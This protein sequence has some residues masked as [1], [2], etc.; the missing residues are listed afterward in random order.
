MIVRLLEHQ[1]AWE[2]HVLLRLYG[3]PYTC[4]F[5]SYPS[6]MGRPLPLLADEENIYCGRECYDFIAKK[7]K[8]YEIIDSAD[9]LVLSYLK[10]HLCD[11]FSDYLNVT[12]ED[13]TLIDKCEISGV[14][15]FQ[16]LMYDFKRVLNQNRY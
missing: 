4:D 1:P 15:S 8:N 2:L 12:R 5:V 10:C 11:M 3:I 7:S 6:A 13:R 9:S 14:S 16:L